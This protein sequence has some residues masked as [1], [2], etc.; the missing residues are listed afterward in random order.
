MVRGPSMKKMNVIFAL[1]ISGIVSSSVLEGCSNTDTEM[2]ERES[3]VSNRTIEQVQDAH[4]AEWMNIS[5]IEGT[6]IGLR[7][8]KPSIIIFSS[9]AA[10]ELKGMIP[11]TV[12]GYPV[13]IEETGTFST[14]E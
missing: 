14:L 2:V 3:A 4:T 13:V 11:A 9:R 8:G 1:F 5:G 7:D 12:E 10:K 6:G